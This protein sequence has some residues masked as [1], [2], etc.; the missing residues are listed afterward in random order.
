MLTHADS[1]RSF[2]AEQQNKAE[3]FVIGHW[4]L[5]L[6]DKE[7]DDLQQRADRVIEGNDPVGG[8][9]VAA[10]LVEA[11]AAETQ[12]GTPDP[13]GVGLK[14]L[15]KSLSMNLALEKLRRTGNLGMS[16]TLAL[17]PCNTARLDASDVP[18][19]WI[20]YQCS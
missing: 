4:L 9:D 6:G 15:A 20:R 8:A 17:D 18:A 11:L 5:T 19:L 3:R 16:G 12:P 7:L 10:T 2:L 14:E 1:L 13:S